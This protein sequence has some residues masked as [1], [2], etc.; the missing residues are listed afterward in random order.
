MRPRSAF[1]LIELLVVISIIALLIGIL[2]PALASARKAARQSASISG[3][4]Q[5]GIGLQAYAIDNKNAFPDV[6]EATTF[7]E[8]WMSLLLPY[9]SQRSF[10][11]SPL[12]Q[13]SAA[14]EADEKFTSYGLNAFV[15]SN[16]PPIWGLK[17]DH[18]VS[19]TNFISVAELEDE[20]D[21]DHFTP[22]LWGDPI[23]TLSTG[24]D[25]QGAAYDLDEDRE[26]NWDDVEHQP[27][28]I[29]LKRHGSSGNY[30]FTDGHVASHP[31]E[32]VFD[33]TPGDVPVV[34][35]FDPRN[36]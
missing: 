13:N 22:M 33:Y 19:P 10:Y 7:E 6:T 23:F 2:L 4:R 30:A 14:W 17:L 16:H 8:T 36:K 18:I 9:I 15:T 29:A 12:D 3:L 11:R 5:I 34:N 24:T 25:P 26:H 31:I 28:G 1:T 20:A 27:L 32:D 21:E 35:R